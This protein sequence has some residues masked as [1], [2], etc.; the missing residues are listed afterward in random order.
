[1]TYAPSNNT[2]SSRGERFRSSKRICVTLNYITYK[3]LEDRST[4]EG[5]SISNLASYLLETSLKE[6][7]KEDQH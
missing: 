1:M 2:S 7:S 6:K 4:R 5:R 3:V